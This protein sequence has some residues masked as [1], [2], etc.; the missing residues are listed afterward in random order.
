MSVNHYRFPVTETVKLAWNKVKG[1][2]A[3]FWAALVVLLLIGSA[4]YGGLLV[5][6]NTVVTQIVLRVYGAIASWGIVYI[7]IQRA[8]TGTIRWGLIWQVF[9]INTLLRMVGLYLI[10]GIFPLLILGAIVLGMS[11]SSDS[12]NGLAL[13]GVLAFIIVYVLYLYISMR[14]FTAPGIILTTDNGPITAIKMSFSATKSNVWRLIGLCLIN[15]VILLI[16]TIPF[17]LGLI[18]SVPYVFIN[19][20]VAYEKLMFSKRED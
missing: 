4:I 9:K 6:G 14:A 12:S 20:G 5:I 18:W 13:I 8:I 2:K 17:G 11:H 16:S 7:G 15:S 3:S 1:A 10:I 19:Y